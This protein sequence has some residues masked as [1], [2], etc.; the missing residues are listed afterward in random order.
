MTLLILLSRQTLLYAIPLLLAAQGGLFSKR[1]GIS[2]L[3]LPSFFMAGTLSSLWALGF[4][5]TR[6]GGPGQLILAAVAA[7]A[8]GALF[9]CLHALAT[10]CLRGEQ[11]VGAMALNLLAWALARRALPG[12][13]TSAAAFQGLFMETAPLLGDL[14]ILGPILFQSIPISF[15]LA[16]LA[17]AFAAVT[18]RRTRLG[19]RLRACGDS[20]EAVELSGLVVGR[21]RAFGVLVSGILGGLGGFALAASMNASLDAAWI[22]QGLLALTVLT[23]GRRRSLRMLP[24][25]LFVGLVQAGTQTGFADQPL[26]EDLR[27]LL[28]YAAALLLLGVAARGQENVGPTERNGL[29]D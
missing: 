27:G 8:G 16:I 28:P 5:A 15:Y 18:L 22:G 3:A 17:C 2:A 20:P 6:M 21:I 26:P 29:L 19:L 11:T 10:A 14:P 1:G 7:M 25:A 23:A 24:A 13:E 12:L 9:S 4:A